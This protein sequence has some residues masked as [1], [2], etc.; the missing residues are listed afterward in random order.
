MQSS[1]NEFH[2]DALCHLGHNLREGLKCLN[3]NGNINSNKAL[4]KSTPFNVKW[5]T[6]S[7]DVTQLNEVKN[8]GVWQHTLHVSWN[9]ERLKWPSK[10]QLE[11]KETPE[12]VQSKLFDVLWNPMYYITDVSELPKPIC[13]KTMRIRQVKSF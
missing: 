7:I 12:F 5:E 10:C 2:K 8:L 4:G 3:Y 13:Q 1:H 11:E 9:D 6:L